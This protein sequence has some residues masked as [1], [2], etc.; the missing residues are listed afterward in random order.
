MAF[1]FA[2]Y[3]YGLFVPELRD[4]F[5]LDQVAVGALG[6]A[7]YVGYLA[8]LLGAGWAGRRYGPRRP[9]L[10]GLAAAAAGCALVAVAPDAR[11]LAA[12]VV[13]A[14]SASGWTWAPFSDAVAVLL[15]AERRDRALSVI[16]T[17]T[18]FGLVALGPVALLAAAT[19]QGWRLAYTA[20]AGG[21]LVVAVAC[22]TLL[23]SARVRTADASGDGTDRPLARPGARRLL[24]CSA[25]YGA[26]AAAVFTFAVDLTR[27]SGSP[28][29]A[30][31]LLFLLV[32]VGGVSG[33]ATDVLV[34]RSG[35]RGGLPL[36]FLGMAVAAVVLAAAPDRLLA[37]GAAGLLHGAAF[38]PVA[39]L[40]VLWNQRLY[41]DR[42]ADGF[43]LTVAALA[44]GSV[45][46]PLPVG[47]LA[48]AVD[49]R[50][51]FLVV[52]V[53]CLAAGALRPAASGVP[54]PR[55]PA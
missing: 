49:L 52:G 42:P 1:G 4:A 40:L 11:V 19:A 23:P 38:M 10:L 50:V 39:A 29:G 5:D 37:V 34:R 24:A 48:D 21:A 33:V 17:G 41:A 9:V 51:A 44:V 3:A 22:W 45:L 16:S 47:W 35:L 36:C 26:V 54:G 12:G 7:G 53:A 32:G 6:S 25:A 43:T 18:T 8:G 27:Q 15:V 13:L 31:A 30:A 2:R 28:P 46:G 14:A 20:F 55:V